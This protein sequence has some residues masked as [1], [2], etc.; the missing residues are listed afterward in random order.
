MIAQ[1]KACAQ[2]RPVK[3]G[4]LSSVVL[5]RVLN[6]SF[7]WEK[8]LSCLILCGWYNSYLFRSVGKNSLPSHQHL[9]A[10]RCIRLA[11]HFVPHG[12]P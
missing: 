10:I 5:S 1:L 12:V 6:E 9:A 4:L 2:L 3:F 11:Q 8:P 7:S